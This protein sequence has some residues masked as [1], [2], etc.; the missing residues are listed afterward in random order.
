[1]S[2]ELCEWRLKVIRVASVSGDG[3]GRRVFRGS[4]TT[5]SRRPLTVRIKAGREIILTHLSAR[6]ALFCP[7]VATSN[8]VRNTNNHSVSTGA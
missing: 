6:S 2:E 4:D 5:G 3:L 8:Y 7:F 1:M